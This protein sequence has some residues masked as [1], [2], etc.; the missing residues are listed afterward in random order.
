[1]LADM[2]ITLL[3]FTIGLKLQVRD[4]LATRIWGTT[5][6]HMLV[7]QLVM[8][9]ILSLVGQLVPGLGLSLQQA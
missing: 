1:V 4:L 7:T 5:L 9:G 6:L 3:L 2:G 8:L